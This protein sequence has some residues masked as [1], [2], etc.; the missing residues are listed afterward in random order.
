MVKDLED[1]DLVDKDSEEILNLAILDWTMVLEEL[2]ADLE[3]LLDQL[4]KIHL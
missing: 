3:V 4:F 1:K 2:A